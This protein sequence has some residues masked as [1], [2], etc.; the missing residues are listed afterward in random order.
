MSLHRYPPG[1]LVGDYGRASIGLVLTG[2]P[3]LAVPAD[4]PALWVLL[5]LIVLFA[6]FGLRTLRRHLARIEVD[7]AGLS[8]SDWRRARLDWSQLTALHVDY[9]STRSDRTG[10]WM[11]M[12]L[13]GPGGPAGASIR[14]DSA[15]D[16]FVAIARAAALSARAN[17]IALSEATR[18]NLG[19]LGIAVDA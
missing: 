4:S 19:H 15:I 17:G 8:H 10:G 1:A 5:P 18:A 7:S 12:T 2:G 9:F 16:D 6:V 11:Q 14:L 3:A 13:K